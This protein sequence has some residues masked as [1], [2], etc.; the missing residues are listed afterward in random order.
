M[1]W[2]SGVSG[3]FWA[4]REALLVSN[5]LPMPGG[6]RHWPAQSGYFDKSYACAQM[7]PVISNAADR[8]TADT[9]IRIELRS[10]MTLLPW[11]RLLR[12]SAVVGSAWL[13]LLFG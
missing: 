10:S 5:W 1:A 7:T 6:R 8:I 2:Y 4:P 12:A 3:G 13:A 9:M 11:L